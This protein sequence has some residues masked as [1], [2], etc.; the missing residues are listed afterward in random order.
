MHRD[1]EEEFC[2]DPPL[3]FPDWE[4]PNIEIGVEYGSTQTGSNLESTHV[5]SSGEDELEKHKDHEHEKF[6][7][8][9]KINWEIPCKH[10]LFS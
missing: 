8:S 6:V 4:G 1:N 5:D 7:K 10:R 2:D 9:S 3:L